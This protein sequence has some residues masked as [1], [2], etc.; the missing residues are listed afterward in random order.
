M[1]SKKKKKSLPPCTKRMNRGQR[2]QSAPNWLAAYEGAHIVRSYRKRHGVDW[3]CAVEE[4]RLLGVEIDPEYVSQLRRTVQE[5][6]K[7]NHEKQLERQK[8]AAAKEWSERYPFSE[9][10]FYFVAGHTS[11]GVPYGITW[12]EARKQGLY[13]RR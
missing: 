4:L 2:L 6:A 7:K 13:R 1:G 12:E 9:G 10:D 8:A 11:N 3:L 5:Q